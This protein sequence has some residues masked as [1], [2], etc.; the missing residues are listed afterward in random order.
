MNF[1]FGDGIKV[2]TT[3]SFQ[4]NPKVYNGAKN[5]TSCWYLPTDDAFKI[6]P[7]I[8]PR[9]MIQGRESPELVSFQDKVGPR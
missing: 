2:S 1:L 5:S 6:G 4:L 3:T 9:P 7:W 8:G